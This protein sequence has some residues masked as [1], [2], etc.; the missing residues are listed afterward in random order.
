MTGSHRDK[1]ITRRRAIAV[2]GGTVAASGLAVAGYQ[3]AFAD[4]TETADTTRT[5]EATATASPS[6]SASS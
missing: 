1:N 3:S 5:A 4:T 6:A 2:T